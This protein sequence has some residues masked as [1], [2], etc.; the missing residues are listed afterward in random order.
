MSSFPAGWY[1]DPDLAGGLRWWD[2]LTWTEFRHPP[3]TAA[4]QTSAQTYGLRSQQMYQQR[5]APSYAASARPLELWEPLYGASASQAFSRFWRKYADFTG[6]ASRSEFWWSY[7]WVVLLGSISYVAVFAVA[8]SNTPAAGG[9]GSAS[10]ITPLG[11]VLVLVWLIGY[12]AM[13]VPTIAVAVRRLHDAGV[14]GLVYL[15]AFVPFGTLVL[16]YFWTQ[17]SKPSGARYDRPRN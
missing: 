7:L 15:L 9:T 5:H 2:G 4:A 8:L 14:S 13:I 1:P 17:D 11:G 16:L 6:R 10:E 12:L 3:V